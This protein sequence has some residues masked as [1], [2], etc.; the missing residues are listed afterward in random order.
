MPQHVV[1]TG[2][3]GTIFINDN[4]VDN[5]TIDMKYGTNDFDSMISQMPWTVTLNGIKQP[6]K[7]FDLYSGD[8][9]QRLTT[10]YVDKGQTVTFHLGETGEPRVGGPS[11]YSFYVQRGAMLSAAYI[12]KGAASQRATAFVNVNGV[13][14][15]AEIYVKYNGEWKQTT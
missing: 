10:L 5:V 14:K 4:G 15:Q 2:T 11:D 7:G 3:D 1:P 9:Y 13:W 8:F 6:W 12:T